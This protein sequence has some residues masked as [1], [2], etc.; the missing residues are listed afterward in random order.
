VVLGKTEIDDDVWHRVRKVALDTCKG[1]MFDLLKAVI[2]FGPDGCEGRGVGM[3]VGRGTADVNKDLRYLRD[4]GACE[5]F[6]P[7]KGG[8]AKTP[9]YRVSGHMAEIYESV[10]NQ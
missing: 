8:T 5:T 4:V 9:R 3:V 6:V 10:V 1:R 7:S 2:D